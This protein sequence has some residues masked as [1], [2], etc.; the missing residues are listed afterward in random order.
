MGHQN[1][2]QIAAS[3]EGFF[4]PKILW[5]WLTHSLDVLV[6]PA[7]IL[8]IINLVFGLFLVAWEWPAPFLAG[9]AIH[10]SIEARL[11][12]LPLS[13]L[14]AALTYQG[15]NAAIYDLIGMAVYFW[16]YS[17]A[18]VSFSFSPLSLLFV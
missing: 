18:E 14:A 7:P 16:A 15:T 12:F 11:V 3:L 6:K 10:R 5:D 1:S 4:W 13:A 8:Q 9:S 17:E 2:D